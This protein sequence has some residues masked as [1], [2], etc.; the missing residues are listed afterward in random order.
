[1][2]NKLAVDVA[3]YTK[4]I[5]PLPLHDASI[6]LM[7]LKADDYFLRN[8]R[9]LVNSGMPIAAYHW[10]DPTRPAGRQVAD[11][12]NI[13]RTSDLPVLAIF[14]DFEQWW[15]RW[16]Q[17][18]K[19]IRKKLAW[20][21]VKRFSGKSLSTHAKQVFD[22]FAAS[23]WKTFGYTRASFITEYA[24]Q[25]SSWMPQYRWWLAHYI[26]CGEQTLTWADLKANILPVVDFFP[27]RPSGITRERVIGHQ[28]TGD[29]L[30]LPGLYEDSLRTKYAAADLNL[31]DEQFLSE[32]GAVPDPKPLPDV[33]HEAMVTAY[34][35]LNI[36]SGP[37]TS[38]PSLYK[39][40]KGTPVKITEL[41]EGWA[42]LRSF[43]EEW[44]SA[45]YLQI[46][47]AEIPEPEPPEPGEE[48]EIPEPI[49]INYPGVTYH[50]LRRYNAD[51]HVL[52]ID[53][54]H[55]RFYVTPYT[56][57]K[58]VSQIARTLNAPIVVNGDGWGIVGYPNS[59]AASNGKVYQA[60]Q[61]SYR[62]WID[63]SKDNQVS[64]D[65]NWR[66]WKRKVYNT[67]SGDRYIINPNG[68]YNQKIDAFNKDPRT[69]IGITQENKLILI[70]AD[71]RT[72]ESAGLSFRE[73]GYLF[74]EFGTKTAINL[75]GG[76]SSALWI[77]DRI[78]NVPIEDGT[79]GKE[80][81][82]A[83]H[84]CVFIN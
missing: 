10:I 43:E 6:Q 34:P 47:D 80:R 4:G 56:G 28:F 49:E 13:L 12:L 30:S 51:C 44:C 17:W 57:L 62:P 53:T 78:I 84:L 63:I 2:F 50:K 66:K 24:P 74:E 5:D 26:A 9:L 64:F 39:L 7:I 18:Y 71:G 22:G 52:I 19:A 31:F 72:N 58:T 79:P 8:A 29:K 32:I 38:Y 82:V 61:Y 59:I 1:M 41:K 35:T 3:N 68:E 48:P 70:V 69:A 16:D 33:L 65:S 27:A 11:T 55:K 14:A 36:R 60:R 23:E 37:S 73:L 25:A 67:V 77:N 20:G 54:S 45:Q 15:S 42:K 75:D 83:N 76:G 21:R 81:A 46:V 40:A